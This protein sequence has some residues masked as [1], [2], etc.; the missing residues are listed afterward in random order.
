MTTTT[1]KKWSSNDSDSWLSYWT[2]FSCFTNVNRLFDYDS[3]FLFIFICGFWYDYFIICLNLILYFYFL[4]ICLLIAYVCTHTLCV[5]IIYCYSYYYLIFLSQVFCFISCHVPTQIIFIFIWIVR[6]FI[7]FF[8]LFFWVF[9]CVL[10]RE[11]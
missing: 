5:R 10:Q 1:T 7:Y 9:L 3:F 2:L 6:R 4:N 8:F 11:F